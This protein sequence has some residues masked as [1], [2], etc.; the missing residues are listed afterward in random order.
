MSDKLIKVK[1]WTKECNLTA[2]MSSCFGK[3][4]AV[5]HLE[6]LGVF[7]MKRVEKIVM[8]LVA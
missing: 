4:T 8:I 5:T 3:Y 2:G 6:A 7:M 1:A